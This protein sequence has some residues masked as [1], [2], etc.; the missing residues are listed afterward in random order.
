MSFSLCA[1]SCHSLQY[2]PLL[3]LQA[4][5]ATIFPVVNKIKHWAFSS[6]F[7]NYKNSFFLLFGIYSCPGELIPVLHLGFK[8]CPCFTLVLSDTPVWPL[9]WWC[10]LHVSF[11]NWPCFAYIYLNTPL[12][13]SLQERSFYSSALNVFIFLKVSSTLFQ[14]C[15]I[16]RF[17]VFHYW[18]NEQV[19]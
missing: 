10:I 7:Y 11:R 6:D 9:Q 3:H 19:P 4:P 1:T 12:I 2:T 18:N 13:K 15:V 8:S 16:N 17:Y 14:K 5:F